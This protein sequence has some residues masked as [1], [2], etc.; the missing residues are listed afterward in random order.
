MHTLHQNFNL[1][2][3][4]LTLDSIHIDFH[5]KLKIFN[6]RHAL[7]C[8]SCSYL[9]STDVPRS[10]QDLYEIDDGNTPPEVHRNGSYNRLVDFYGVGA[11]LSQICKDRKSF[12]E[13]NSLKNF[14]RGGIEIAIKNLMS[15]SLRDREFF[16]REVITELI[17]EKRNY[18]ASQKM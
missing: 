15:E 12:S 9:N 6:Y 13:E 7:P 11:I 14:Q 8:F 4:N 2:H 5:G 18:S 1:L 16:T 3:R 10:Y 17:E